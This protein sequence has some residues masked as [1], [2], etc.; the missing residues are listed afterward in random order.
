MVTLEGLDHRSFMDVVVFSAASVSMIV[1][2]WYDG[3]PLGGPTDVGLPLASKDVEA[4][5]GI[6]IYI[7]KVEGKYNFTWKMAVGQ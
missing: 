6:Y 4:L 5:P 2:C 3:L 1:E 7:Y